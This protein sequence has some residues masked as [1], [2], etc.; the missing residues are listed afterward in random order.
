MF[1]LLLCV[2]A[3]ILLILIVTDPFSVNL[4]ALPTR[5]NNIWLRRF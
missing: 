2:S 4:I 5:F 1:L 3:E